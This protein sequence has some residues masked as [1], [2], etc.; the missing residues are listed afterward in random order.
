M[1]QVSKIFAVIFCSLKTDIS[2]VVIFFFYPYSFLSSFTAHPDLLDQ[3]ERKADDDFCRD[4]QIPVTHTHISTRTFRALLHFTLS[5]SDLRSEERGKPWTSARRLQNHLKWSWKHRCTCSHSL[6]VSHSYTSLQYQ[7]PNP[8]LDKSRLTPRNEAHP[9]QAMELVSICPQV[10][11]NW[12]S[13]I[14]ASTW[15]SLTITLHLQKHHLPVCAVLLINNSE[16]FQLTKQNIPKEEWQMHFLL[17][18]IRLKAPLNHWSL[19][20]KC[21]FTK[22]LCLLF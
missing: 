2:N 17:T 14:N 11:P 3:K 9:S 16:L 7:R 15:N 8:P 5:P 22:G 4:K 1:F 12:S 6:P 20:T 18:G 10:G 21:S 13:F 19:T